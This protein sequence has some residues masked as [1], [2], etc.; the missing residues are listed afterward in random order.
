MAHKNP[1]GKIKDTAL[2]T[3][4]DPRGTAEKAVGQAKAP[5]PWVGWSRSR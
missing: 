2:E 4:R 3:L 1:L 5:S